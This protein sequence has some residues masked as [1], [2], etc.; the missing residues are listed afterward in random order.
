MAV[1]PHSRTVRIRLTGRQE[2]GGLMA[3]DRDPPPC[4]KLQVRDFVGMSQ[5][6]GPQE[7]FCFVPHELRVGEERWGEGEP[8][9][10][11]RHEKTPGKLL[12][13]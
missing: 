2:Q 13:Q 12:L 11:N 4:P 7:L 9:M 10:G 5:S 8:A 1:G 6:P 3:Q